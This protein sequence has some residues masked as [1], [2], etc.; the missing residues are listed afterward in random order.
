MAPTDEAASRVQVSSHDWSPRSISG[1][2]HELRT[3]LASLLVS[4]ELLADDTRLGER[5]S[6]LARSLH[7]AAADLRALIDDLGE[8]NRIRGGR[9]EPAAAPVELVSLLEELAATV[10][11]RLATDGV[12]LAVAVDPASP[13]E[14][15]TD[16]SRLLRALHEL[17]LSAAKSGARRIEVRAAMEDSPPRLLLTVSDDG[18]RLDAPGVEALC[19]PFALAHA[20]TRRVHGGMGLGPAL[21]RAIARLLGGDV[22]IT[23]D[24]TGT[25]ALLS[26]PLAA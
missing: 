2:I 8:L 22:S 21:A 15:R 12:E 19:E 6:R 16:R 11:D 18:E 17:V 26:L 23:S 4:A 14:V 5:Q 24:D 1:L 25:S 3:P 20:R 9:V 10:R 7:D 13:A